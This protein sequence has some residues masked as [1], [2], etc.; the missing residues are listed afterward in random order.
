VQVKR[1]KAIH[2]KDLRDIV[3]AAIPVASKAPHAFIVAVACGAS[4]RCFDAL[5]AAAKARGVKRIELWDK[6]KVNDF[7]NEPKNALTSTFYFGDG[8]AI[9]G[10]VPLPLALDRSIGRDAP[11]IGRASEVAD[12]LAAP[13]DVVIV[14][15][16]GTGKSR[17]AAEI[18]GR[19][20]LTTHS[21]PDAV[22]ASVRNDHPTH[23][24]IDDAGL[25]IAR[26]NMLLELRQQSYAFKIV[27]TTW[28]E[29]LDDVRALLPNA[30]RIE[31]AELERPAMDQTLKAIG[32]GNY[33]LRSWILDLAEG[34]PGW[35]ISLTQLAKE[36]RIRDVRSGRGLIESI[37][38]YLNRVNPGAGHRALALLGVLA[39]VGPVAEDELPALD[40]I[41]GASPVDRHSLLREAA[42]VGM[43]ELRG[44]SL[45]VVP[46][47]LRPA[48][49]AHLF[50]E[51]TARLRI[52]DV[53][54]AFPNRELVMLERVIEAAHA[55]SV[56]A[57]AEVDRRLPDLT[58]LLDWGSHSLLVAFATL[59]EAAAL[60]ALSAT[61]SLDPGHEARRR[62]VRATAERFLMADAIAAMLSDAIG[63]QRPENSTPEHPVRFLGEMARQV[64]PLNQ[65]SFELRAPI[66][67]ATNQWLEEDP[68]PERQEI[69]ARVVAQ[70]LDPHVA[71]VFP[72][73]GSPMTIHLP[74]GAESEEHI[75]EIGT[76][77]WPEVRARLA[78]LETSA[79]VLLAAGARELAEIVRRY[80]LRGD[81]IPPPGASTAASGVLDAMLPELAGY[82]PT[83]PAL[84]LTLHR[85]RREMGVGPRQPID[86]EFRLLAMGWEIRSGGGVSKHISH[87]VDRLVAQWLTEPAEVVMARV[88][89]WGKEASLARRDLDPVGGMA[90]RRYAE[91]GG[92]IDATVSAAL[93][94]GL[95]GPEMYPLIQ[96]GMAEGRGVPTWL[97][98]VF[99]GQLRWPA[100]SVALD[101]GADR[102]IAMLAVA[103]LKDG[104]AGVV[105]ESALRHSHHGGIQSEDLLLALLTHPVKVVRGS[106]AIQFPRSGPGSPSTRSPAFYSAWKR[107]FLEVPIGDHHNWHLGQHLNALA[108]ADPQLVSDWLLRRA[109]DGEA[110]WLLEFEKKLDVSTMPRADRDALMRSVP[111]KA[112]GQVLGLVLGEDREWASS[113][114]DGGVCSID[115][116]WHAIAR[117]HHHGVSAAEALA[118]APTLRRHGARDVEVL[119]LMDLG[120]SGPE[121]GHYANLKAALEAEPESADPVAEAVRQAG[122]KSFADAER[123]AHEREHRERVTG[124]VH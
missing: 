44:T 77:L 26:L 111:D 55:G 47:A 28:A 64:D 103:E 53:L 88:A 81:L 82:A 109:T 29:R 32:V 17:L 119:R 51:G 35:A 27:A 99:V 1:Y 67:A 22:A 71:G 102:L 62:V 40:S 96:K 116:I 69:W 41:L 107:A 105:D 23:V 97:G 10:T 5:D 113:L 57:R 63:D 56:P 13:G 98:Q 123:S 78:L 89:M 83:R 90:L 60:R 37:G 31:I 70:L 68:N 65:T 45:A 49:V 15:P 75:I 21:T 3:D 46:Q 8:S 84:Q 25:D 108:T 101:P 9:P 73:S 38:P 93:A 112:K 30:T 24:V 114:V 124:R 19:R 34:R 33:Y 58:H 4:K 18:P 94:A 80:P 104:D 120:H 7:L 87:A 92:D 48:L 59:D 52:P 42:A 61:D 74:A 66:L 14:G 50:F 95:P 39:A 117:Q 85:L 118:W 54:A 20:F 6:E 121:S 11:L 79:F 12:L 106:A 72:D 86:P 100:L 115:H 76:T 16:A 2:P 43:I 91:R 122:I 36:G 110:M